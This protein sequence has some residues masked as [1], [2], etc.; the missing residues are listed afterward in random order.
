MLKAEHPWLVVIHCAN[1][2]LA[3]E[4]KDAV[5]GIVEFAECGSFRKIGNRDERGLQSNWHYQRYMEQ[6]LL[7]IKDKVSPSCY[8][9]I[10]ALITSLVVVDGKSIQ[11]FK[12]LKSYSFF[13]WMAAYLDILECF[14]IPSLTEKCSNGSWRQDNSRAKCAETWRIVEWRWRRC[15][16]KFPSQV[17]H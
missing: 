2:R 8:K 4:I 12:K 15:T 16:H 1:L 17:H 9:G 3:L 11:K 7:V 6:T 10:K 5:K 14:L 13:Y